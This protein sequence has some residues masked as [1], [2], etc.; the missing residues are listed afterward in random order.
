MFTTIFAINVHGVA[1][2]LWSRL[3]KLI[4]T[5]QHIYILSL[6]LVMQTRAMVIFMT[7]QLE[8]TSNINGGLAY[9]GDVGFSFM[10]I[11]QLNWGW[12]CCLNRYNTY[13]N[14][15]Q[16]DVSA[17]Y[18]SWYGYFQGRVDASLRV[19]NIFAAGVAIWVD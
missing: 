3:V 7:L 19:V 15:K 16:T 12:A 4:K 13:D 18:K 2:S 9:Q 1:M 14:N 11:S 17:S 6:V 5:F 8:D 10:P